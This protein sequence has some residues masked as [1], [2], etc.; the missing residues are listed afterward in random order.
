MNVT[1]R[2]WPGVVYVAMTDVL[3]TVVCLHWKTFLLDY[4]FILSYMEFFVSQ[5][6]FIGWISANL[7]NVE[8]GK[9]FV[10]I[11]KTGIC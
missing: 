3:E 5:F 8:M 10:K 6:V 9:I 11:I 7:E 1:C 2:I 4:K